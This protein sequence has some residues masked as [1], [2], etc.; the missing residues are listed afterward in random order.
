MMASKATGVAGLLL[1]RQRR[2]G[3]GVG[4]MG[5]GALG[6]LFCFCL[7]ATSLYL[8]GFRPKYHVVMSAGMVIAFASVKGLGFESR[9]MVF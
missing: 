6:F 1:P 4:M 5:L 7:W 9:E 8:H 2:P 3:T